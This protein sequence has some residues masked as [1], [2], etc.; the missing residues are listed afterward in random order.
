MW[1]P[2]ETFGVI[3]MLVSLVVVM[4]SW[5]YTDVSI[6]DEIECFKY[7]QFSVH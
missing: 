2:E 6:K 3:D 7:V 4:V 1:G 5:V